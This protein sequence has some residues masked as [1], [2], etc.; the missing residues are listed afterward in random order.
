MFESDRALAK[1]VE[2]MQAHWPSQVKPEW[3][4]GLDEYPEIAERVVTELTADATRN[5]K[6]IRIAGVSG[7]GKTTQ[8]LPAVEAYVEKN[9]LKPIL[10]AARRF[11]KYHPHYK[12]ILECYGE[13]NLRKLTDEFSTI[14]LFLTLIKLTQGGYDIVLDVTLLDPEM[15]AILLK[16]TT[17]HQYDMTILMIAVSPTVTEHFLQGR[18]WRHTKETEEEFIRATEK[19]LE[20]YATK[21]PELRII[22]WSVYDLMPVY[23][24]PVKECLATFAEYSQ[25]SELPQKD[26]DLRREEKI[27]YLLRVL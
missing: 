13:E 5:R 26:D 16:M 19:A 21:A 15:E 12:E 17:T 9:E 4:V 7:S 27:K 23:D 11:V 14:M 8:I 10:M 18:P 22:M 6:L 25:R 2:Y 1:I 20:F 3:R 24:G